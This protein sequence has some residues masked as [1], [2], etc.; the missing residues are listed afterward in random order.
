MK[1]ALPAMAVALLGMVVIWAKLAPQA[2]AFKIGFA[3]LDQDAVKTLSMM[4]PRYFGI[5]E[6]NHP[7]SVTADKATQREQDQDLVDLDQ[8]KADFSSKSGAGVVVTADHGLFH[9]HSQLLDLTGNVSLFHDQGYELHTEQASVDMK[10]NSA[11]GNMPIDGQG[12]QGHL[13]G[14][15]FRISDKGE[16]ILVTGRSSMTLK[17]VSGGQ[18]GHSSAQKGNSPA[19]DGAP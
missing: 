11:W 5:D 2:D 19:G 1:L 3:H 16:K 17:G 14:E 10:N 18:G 13:E 4:N 7:Y 8:P 12:P 6:N 15:G 9:Q